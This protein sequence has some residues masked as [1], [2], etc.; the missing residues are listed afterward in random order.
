MAASPPETTSETVIAAC[1]LLA[2]KDSGSR[3]WLSTAISVVLDS[4][5]LAM[6]SYTI[7]APNQEPTKP[8]TESPDAMNPLCM[9]D[10]SP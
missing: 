5:R 9:P 6:R 10:K 7:C 4:A 8:A 3:Y 1:A 2:K